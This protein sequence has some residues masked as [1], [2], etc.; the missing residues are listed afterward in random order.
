LHGRFESLLLDGVFIEVYLGL[1]IASFER[2]HVSKGFKKV[3][4]VGTPHLIAWT[5]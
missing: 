4:I 1:L 5:V 2:A 3:S